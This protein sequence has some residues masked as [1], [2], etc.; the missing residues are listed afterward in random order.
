MTPDAE[1]FQKITNVRLPF[2]RRSADPKTN[3]GIHGLDIWF[4]LKG[5]KGAVQFAINFPI[6]LPHVEAE[7]YA[8]KYKPEIMG[9]DIGYHALEP[10]YEGQTKMECQMFGEC[11]YDGSSLRADDW[12]KEIFAI[13]GTHL[14]DEIWSRLEEDYRRRFDKVKE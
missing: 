14:E 6:Y 9:I 3:Y 5:P 8:W 12:V 7:R 4:I 13:R 1:K 2:D 10:Q 11:Y